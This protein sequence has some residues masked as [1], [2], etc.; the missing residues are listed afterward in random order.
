MNDTIPALGQFIEPAP[1]QF[2]PDAPGWYVVGGIIALILL[3]G[4]FLVWRSY[5]KNKYRR[6]AIQWLD[7]QEN[8]LFPQ[9]QYESLIYQAVSLS[10]RVGML[11]YGRETVASLNGKGWLDFMNGSGRTHIFMPEDERLLGV[12]Y[13]TGSGDTLNDTDVKT[14]V[15][16]VKQWIRKHK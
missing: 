14:F 16:K 8:L 15:H 9:K 6:T 13:K 4:L 10:K 7:E 12:L 11:K 2:R 5:R 1:V 3:F